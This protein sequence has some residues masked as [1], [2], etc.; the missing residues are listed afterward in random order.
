MKAV[1]HLGT[2]VKFKSLFPE[3]QKLNPLSNYGTSR[4]ITEAGWGLKMPGLLFIFSTTSHFSS[5]F[6]GNY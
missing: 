4:N 6:L 1:G 2:D 3:G 5:F